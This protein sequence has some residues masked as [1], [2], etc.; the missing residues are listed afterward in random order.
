[1]TPSA[2]PALRCFAL[3]PCAGTGTRAGAPTP[4]QYVRID[5]APMVSHTLAALAAVARLKL[6]LVALAPDDEEFERRV[7]LPAGKRFAI[8]RCGGNSRA[9]TVAA[10]LSRLLKLGARADDWVLVHDAARCLVRAE[11]IDRL[12]D[13]CAD[14]PVGGLLAMPVADTLK[15]E[16]S[17]RVLTTLPRDAVWQAQ[18]PQMFRLGPLADA[19]EDAGA[20]ATDEASAME[21]Q[22]LS[23]RLVPGSSENFKITQP[24]DFLLAEAVLRARREERG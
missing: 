3:V 2:P 13:V 8:S 23:P 22:G 14:D 10:G 9:E 21:W 11:W 1:M 6:V 20:N 19:L 5:G 4:K 12:I 18:T 15:R 17:G 16:T 7:D 24:E